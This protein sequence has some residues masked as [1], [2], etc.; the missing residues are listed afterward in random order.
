MVS[1]VA[2]PCYETV[3]TG[4]IVPPDLNDTPSFLA[5]RDL[6]GRCSR[7]GRRDDRTAEF[8]GLSYC[9]SAILR[10]LATNL[11]TRLSAL[12]ALIF[13]QHRTVG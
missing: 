9:S 12:I 3:L 4:A 13:F 6:C 11:I 7:S 5:C 8:W 10:L 1:S 2:T